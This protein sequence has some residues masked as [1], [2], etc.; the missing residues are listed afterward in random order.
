[1][2]DDEMTVDYRTDTEHPTGTDSGNDSSND[3]TNDSGAD[4]NAEEEEDLFQE[5]EDAIKEIEQL[6]KLQDTCISRLMILKEYS[7]ID[8]SLSLSVRMNE[9]HEEAM[10]A[11]RNKTPN[12]FLSGLYHAIDQWGS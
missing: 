8:P 6:Q 10:N 4:S 9:L 5:F 3:S 7:P 11:I 1:M 12:P 2:S